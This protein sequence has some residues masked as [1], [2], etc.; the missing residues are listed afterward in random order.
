[1]LRFGADPRRDHE[2]GL[3]QARIADPA[4][5]QRKLQLALAKA[6]IGITAM[7]EPYAEQLMT[8]DELRALEAAPAHPPDQLARPTRRPAHRP[9]A[10]LPGRRQEAAAALEPR[11]DMSKRSTVFFSGCYEAVVA[12]YTEMIHCHRRVTLAQEPLI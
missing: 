1:M 8:I 10:C 2:A 6:A 11:M 3:E 5:W 7:I 9:E 12:F 4:T